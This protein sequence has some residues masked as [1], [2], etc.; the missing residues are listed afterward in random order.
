[1]ILEIQLG[2]RIS[3]ENVRGTGDAEGSM[4][5]EWLVDWEDK[6]GAHKTGYGF[7]LVFWFELPSRLSGHELVQGNGGQGGDYDR[8]FS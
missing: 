2:L 6:D 8:H 7:F 1:M 4:T 3:I 5:N